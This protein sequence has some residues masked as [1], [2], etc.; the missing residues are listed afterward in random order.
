MGD[1]FHASAHITLQ[2]LRYLSVVVTSK[3]TG[4][5]CVV[6]A[7]HLKLRNDETVLVDGVNYLAG[8]HV[9]IGLQQGEL[10]FFTSGESLSCGSVSVVS[11]L[12]LSCVDSDNGTHVEVLLL[13]AGVGHPLQETSSV[14]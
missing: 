10:S 14:F 8:V 6:K 3:E 12:E 11:D 9:R 1:D 5:S 2:V 13:D 4:S 7:A